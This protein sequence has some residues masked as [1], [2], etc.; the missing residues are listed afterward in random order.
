[1][2][3]IVYTCVWEDDML[4]FIPGGEEDDHIT[5]QS[6]K[7]G[8]LGPECPCAPFIYEGPIHYGKNDQPEHVVLHNMTGDTR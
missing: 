5:E 8:I 3:G 1:M 7:L 4:H 2:I 6:P